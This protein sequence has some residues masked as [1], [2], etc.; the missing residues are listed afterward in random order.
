MI[1]TLMISEKMATPG[2][3][4][5]KNYNVIFSVQ[6]VTNKILSRDSNHNFD[7]VCDSNISMKEAILTSVLQRFDQK[8]HF[9]WGLV[10]S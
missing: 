2:L 9:Q 3:L 4:K 1:L 8:K 5:L 7:L 6:D 10:S